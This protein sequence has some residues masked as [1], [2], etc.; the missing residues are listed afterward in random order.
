MI[1]YGYMLM[2]DKWKTVYIYLVSILTAFHMFWDKHENYLVDIEEPM[3]ISSK[4]MDILIIRKFPNVFEKEY[5][6]YYCIKEHN[7]NRIILKA[8]SIL[9]ILYILMEL[10]ELKKVDYLTE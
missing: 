8:A 1:V 2:M 6:N 4:T 3:K 5:Q 7:W 9:I 10:K